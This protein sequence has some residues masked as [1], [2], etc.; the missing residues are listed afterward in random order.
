MKRRLSMNCAWDERVPIGLNPSSAS[1]SADLPVIA[2]RATAR[3]SSREETLEAGGTAPAHQ[4]AIVGS[5]V[6]VRPFLKKASR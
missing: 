4:V 2:C 3:V 5:S 6:S 1:S